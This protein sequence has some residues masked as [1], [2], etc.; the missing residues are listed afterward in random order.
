MNN[1]IDVYTIDEAA[2]LVGISKTLLYGEIRT[3]RLTVKKVG[4]R[5]LITRPDLLSWLN[6]RGGFQP[7]D[8]GGKS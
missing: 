8:G 7:K 4:R 1:E 5:T 2:K 3:E 6:S